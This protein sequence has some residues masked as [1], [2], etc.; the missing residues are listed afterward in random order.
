MLQNFGASGQVARGSVCQR[1]HATFSRLDQTHRTLQP[2]RTAFCIVF[3]NAILLL[4]LSEV[5]SFN[6]LY[7]AVENR[8]QIAEMA[9]ISHNIKVALP[10]SVSTFIFLALQPIIST[11]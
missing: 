4:S 3:V 6:V 9:W 5:E 11:I 7:L 2:G 10:L 1:W 8:K